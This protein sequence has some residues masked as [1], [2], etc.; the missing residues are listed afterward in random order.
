[1]TEMARREEQQSMPALVGASSLL[2][3]FSC[4]CLAVFAVL[5]IATVQMNQRL[6]KPGTDSVTEYFAADTRANEWL[7]ELR[8]SGAEGIYTHF[9]PISDTQELGCEVALDGT[10]YV[11]L[12]WQKR[13]IVDW[14]A[15]DSLDVWDGDDWG[16]GLFIPNF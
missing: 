3:I 11:I 2:V 9:E 8:E 16:G 1:M 15:D 5:S 14:E 12:T 7:A 10:G 4:L 6:T 13:P